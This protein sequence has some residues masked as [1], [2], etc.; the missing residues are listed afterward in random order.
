MANGE[1]TGNAC[2]GQP[3]VCCLALPVVNL[4]YDDH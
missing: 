1:R 4:V 2:L 3:Q